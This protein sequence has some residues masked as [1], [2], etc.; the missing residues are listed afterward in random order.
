[1]PSY[2][3][4]LEFEPESHSQPHAELIPVGAVETHLSTQTAS[5]SIFR[6][7]LNSESMS[8]LLFLGRVRARF[9]DLPNESMCPTEKHVHPEARIVFVA[10]ASS[11]KK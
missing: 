6:Q 8:K 1:M 3:G 5:L 10:R 2:E 11:R 9:P 7:S 4:C